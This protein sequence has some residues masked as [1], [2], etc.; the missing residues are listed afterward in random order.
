MNLFNKAV[1]SIKRQ[2]VKNLLLFLI[3][4][5]SSLFLLF[6]LSLANGINTVQNNIIKNLNPVI[7]L[8]RYE[9]AFGKML[10]NDIIDS[11]TNLDYVRGYNFISRTPFL[12]PGNHTVFSYHA[13]YEFDEDVNNWLNLA[14]KSNT[15]RN[16]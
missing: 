14:Y 16:N 8:N 1:L 15:T 3:I 12:T 6:S 5:T 11:I 9:E 2:P 10:T 7:A 4:L 13:F